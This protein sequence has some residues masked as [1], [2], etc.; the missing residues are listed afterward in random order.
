MVLPAAVA[1]VRVMG[2]LA[3]THV[4]LSQEVVQFNVEWCH[5]GQLLEH[6][7]QKFLE[8]SLSL[9]LTWWQC[10]D[11]GHRLEYRLKE[12]D[13]LVLLLC[14]LVKALE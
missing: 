8:V 2:L 12:L 4:L 7:D 9:G 10:L 1:M 6:L 11:S 5:W 13:Y 14:A 3:S